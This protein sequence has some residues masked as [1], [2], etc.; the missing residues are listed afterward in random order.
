MSESPVSTGEKRSPGKLVLPSLFFSRFATQPA[1]LVSSLLLVDIGLTFG[2]SVGVTGQIR[3]AFYVASVIFALLMG[4]LSLR[5]RHK[6]LLIMGLVLF[7]ISALGC[8]FAPSFDTMLVSYS[9][10]GLGMAMVAPMCLTL[11]GE[12]FPREKRG[13][14]IGWVFAGQS[15]AYVIGAPAIGFIAGFGGWRLA[16]LGFVLPVSLFSLLLAVKGMPSALSGQQSVVSVGDYLTGFKGVF[17]FRSADACLAGNA[18]SMAAWAAILTYAPSFY[19]QRFLVSTGF[20]SVFLFVAA[21]CYT[22]G[23]LVGGRIVKRIGRKP[24][25]ALAAFFAGLM[26]IAYTMSFD[27]WLSLFTAF[28]SSLFA[29]MRVTASNSLTLEQVPKF[30]GTM[31]SISSAADNLGSSLGAGIGGLALLS[32]GYEGMAISL[33]AMGVAAA[34]VFQL[35]AVDPTKAETQTRS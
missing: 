5:F 13:S 24:L 12:H 25:S 3:T 18:L 2:S 32:F 21:L 29:G 1:G 31:M 27:L 26:I 4:I 14:V 6:S 23:S 7:G 16:F 8:G 15:I 28:L 9:I 20:A 30:R 19:R 11:V 33:G 17:S 34:T 22:S 10:G 35:L